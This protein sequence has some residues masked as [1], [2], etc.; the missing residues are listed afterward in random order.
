MQPGLPAGCSAPLVIDVLRQMILAPEEN[1][2]SW[3]QQ[4][5]AQ[6]R[7]VT[8]RQ[9]CRVRDHYRLEKKRPN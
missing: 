7:P 5:Q 8:A 9:V 3:A 2:E 4:L 1:P 6:G